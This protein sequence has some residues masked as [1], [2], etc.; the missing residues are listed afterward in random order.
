[1]YLPQAVEE[2]LRS[3][4][5]QRKIRLFSRYVTLGSARGAEMIAE[6]QIQAIYGTQ[7]DILLDNLQWDVEHDTPISVN[8]GIHVTVNNG[9]KPILEL[10]VF[11]FTPKEP[12]LFQHIMWRNSNKPSFALQS[13]TYYGLREM[14]LDDDLNRYLDENIPFIIAD[15]ERNKSCEIEFETC[16]TAYKYS[17]AN[18]SVLVNFPALVKPICGSD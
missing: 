12:I 4:A 6:G 18:N 1:M 13:A 17:C 15:L 16:N 7:V 2:Y 11:P 5:F 9:Y 3:C 10:K 8:A 14:L